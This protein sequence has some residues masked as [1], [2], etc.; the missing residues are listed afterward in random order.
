[1]K[2]VEFFK[3]HFFGASKVLDKLTPYEKRFAYAED[4]LVKKKQELR[5]HA[6]KIHSELESFDEKRTKAKRNYEYAMAHAEQSM[7]KGD[8]FKAELQFRQAQTAKK[9]QDIYD[10][11]YNKCLENCNKV[12][13]ALRDYEL[14]IAKTRGKMSELK[15]LAEINDISKY[16]TDS[17]IPK[18]IM[19][20][21]ENIEQEIKQDTFTRIATEKVDKIEA[22]SK[23]DIEGDIEKEAEQDE[24]ANWAA[25][26]ETKGDDRKKAPSAKSK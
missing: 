1:M 12:D 6:I 2:L 18:D 11:A 16:V 15:S 19:S 13:Q 5:N 25:Q 24:F 9:T 20:F 10:Q 7:T 26:F 21:L 22:E 23:I 4:Q 14:T 8:K 17:G 3:I